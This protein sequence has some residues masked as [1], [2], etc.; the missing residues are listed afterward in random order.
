MNNNWLG[1]MDKVVVIMGVVGGMGIK[2]CEEFV[3]Q[4]VKIVLIDMIVDKIEVY[5]K[6]LIEKYGVEMLVVKCNMINE[7][8][9]DV[10]VKVV[11]DKFGEVDVLVNM[12][13]ILCF[14]LFE[15]LCLDEW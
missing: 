14:L 7:E 12:V 1:L 13:V 9:V 4:G 6:K 15:D 3:K 2:F 8:E 11:I 5:V 10:V